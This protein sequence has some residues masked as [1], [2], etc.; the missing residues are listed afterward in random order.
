MKFASRLLLLTFHLIIFTFQPVTAQTTAPCGYVDAI[1]YPLDINDTV[2]RN[3]DDFAL[4]RQRWGGLHTGFDLAFDRYGEQIYAAARGR[5]TLANLEEWDSERGV[6]VIEHTLESGE[7][8]YTLYGHIEESPIYPLPRVDSCVARGDII[9]V[10]G[11]PDQSRPHLH[12]EIRDFLPNSGGP[13]YVS[14]N[15]ML[16]GWYHPLEFTTMLRARLNGTLAQNVPF[17]IVP[18][19]PP[20]LL[21]NGLLAIAHEK[22]INVVAASGA[23]LWSVSVTDDIN[24]LIGLS[25]NRIVART[26]TGSAFTVQNGRYLA[27]WQVSI[28]ESPIYKLGET[29]IFASEQGA[30]TAFNA[31]GDQV[32][33]L[34]APN[35]ASGILD[36]NANGSSLAIATRVADNILWRVVD[37]NGAVELEANL[38]FPPTTTPNGTGWLL[39][40]GS[41]VFKSQG[42]VFS[43]LGTLSATGRSS[44]GAFAAMVSDSQ[45]NTYIFAGGNDSTLLSLSPSGAVRWQVDYPVE[46]RSPTP[47]LSISPQACALYTLDPDGMLNAFDPNDGDLIAQ[48][49]IYAGGR[50]GNVNGRMLHAFS[51][52]G[53]VISSGFLSTWVMNGR[54]II[55]QNGAC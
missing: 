47:L 5:V 53:L 22:A 54:N 55:T 23:I 16:Q 44:M 21:D 6:I 35:G 41:Q 42:D 9:A 3:F 45:N 32:W 10:I 50:A 49:P 52:E 27:Q 37:A 20:V 24:G 13:G 12:Y 34:P 51:G 1:D 17:N 28:S 39:L 33:E 7:I 48:V 40:T 14:T 8:F 25:D 2:R 43:A 26:A 38:V 11:D 31:S 15:P 30:L 18:T 19:L 29:L 4:Y 46:L 36:F